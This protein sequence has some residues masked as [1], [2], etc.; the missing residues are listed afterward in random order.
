MPLCAAF[1]IRRF[2]QQRD[3]STEG[4]SLSQSHDAIGDNGYKKRFSIS[5][6]L[7]DSFPKK[8]RKAVI[9]AANTCTV[10]KV[11]QAAPEFKI[12][13]QES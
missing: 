6:E 8:Y 2:C 12:N 4:I 3:I 13:L 1:Y 11:I 10:K 7:P 5:V 9:A